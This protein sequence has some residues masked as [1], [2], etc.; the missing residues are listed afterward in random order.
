M[1]VVCGVAPVVDVV[2][3]LD[4]RRPRS[5]LSMLSIEFRDHDP[6]EISTEARHSM[7]IFILFS[8]N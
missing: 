6:I 7:T 1:Y 5:M 4:W 2:P 3:A 8:Y